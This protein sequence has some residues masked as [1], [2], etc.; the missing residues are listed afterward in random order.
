MKWTVG[1]PAGRLV[2]PALNRRSEFGILVLDGEL[3][4]YKAGV[5]PVMVDLTV[6]ARTCLPRT[7]SFVT[8]EPSSSII[9]ACLIVDQFK[10]TFN[11][12]ATFHFDMNLPAQTYHV[13]V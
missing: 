9:P 3:R 1:P 2:L 12:S 11:K 4:I 10:I 8:P 5:L 7:E 13:M 6:L